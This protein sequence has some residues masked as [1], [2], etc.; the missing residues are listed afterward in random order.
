MNLVIESIK[1]DIIKG[2]NVLHELKALLLFVESQPHTIRDKYKALALD[3]I[4]KIS[5]IANEYDEESL[6]LEADAKHRQEIVQIR[7]KS[8]EERLAIEIRHIE[9]EEESLN[10]E[11]VNVEESINTQSGDIMQNKA[12]LEIQLSTISNEIQD[13]EQLLKMKK[14]EESKL[15]QDLQDIDIKV[16]SVRKRYEK[17][18]NR[19]HDR[20]EL[21]S[22]TKY[23]CFDEETNYKKE[24]ALYESD[25]V[26]STLERDSFV[27]FQNLLLLESS[28]LKIL[29]ETIEEIEKSKVSCLTDSSKEYEDFKTKLAI[30]ETELLTV[31]GNKTSITNEIHVLT[32][33]LNDLIEETL[34]KLEN[35]K[36][37]HASA[38]R[39]K[40]ASV[41][42]K[43]LK[44]LSSK[45]EEMEENVTSLNENLQ[46]TLQDLLA[47]EAKVTTAQKNFNEIQRDSDFKKYELLKTQ[48]QSLDSAKLSIS[49]LTKSSTDNFSH[50]CIEAII[51]YIDTEIEIVSGVISEIKNKHSISEEEPMKES[52][53]NDSVFSSDT[54]EVLEIAGSA[55]N[56][57]SNDDV[58]TKLQS[59][60]STDFVIEASEDLE[61]E[62]I[63]N[64][65]KVC[66]YL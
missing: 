24:L 32:Q 31:I 53:H 21:L 4:T 40:E 62:S 34:P 25:V 42:A 30:A 59:L 17:Q 49:N 16:S 13:L 23:E 3:T 2:N 65:A 27:S 18:L 46:K 20:Q 33:E 64:E 57:N 29:S 7:L 26:N 43:E 35:E 15:I 22:K 37:S 19:I 41:V 55:D 11:K 14:S 8:E 56:L 45:K 39:F 52:I 66:S 44:S 1:N 38:K 61:L 50:D 48:N 51:S 10:Q 9:K 36:K 58:V 60:S 54:S 47:A 63:V 5:S 6:E 28:A 12:I